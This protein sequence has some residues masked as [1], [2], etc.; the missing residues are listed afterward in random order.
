MKKKTKIFGIR[1]ELR[2]GLHLTI[3]VHSPQI[4]QSSPIYYI[5]CDDCLAEWKCYHHFED[6]ELRSYLPH[7]LPD[8]DIATK[9]QQGHLSLDKFKFMQQCQYDLL[10]KEPD[11]PCIIVSDDKTANCPYCGGGLAWSARDCR[12]WILRTRYDNISTRSILYYIPNVIKI[13]ANWGGYIEENTK[14]SPNPEKHHGYNFHL[15]NSSGSILFDDFVHVEN[16]I[17]LRECALLS[18][19]YD[20]NTDEIQNAA[21]ETLTLGMSEFDSKLL[22]RGNG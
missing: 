11:Y 19:Y 20:L 21:V 12:H 18:R 1:N 17:V 22:L 6:S 16:R 3:D 8:N 4:N 15:W 9:M 5:F 10:N 7:S 2:R 14:R 13:D